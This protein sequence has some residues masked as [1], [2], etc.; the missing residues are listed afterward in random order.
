MSNAKNI[1]ETKKPHWRLYLAIQS[2]LVVAAV[3]LGG[4]ELARRGETYQNSI[5]P[6]L[7]L[8]VFAGC[9]AFLTVTVHIG[10]QFMLTGRQRIISTMAYLCVYVASYSVLS[11]AGKYHASRS[12]GHRWQNAGFAVVDQTIW[13]AKGVFWQPFV[14]IRGQHTYHATELGYFYSPLIQ[15]DRRYWHDS[16]NQFEDDLD[17]WLARHQEAS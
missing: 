17:E 9:P 2:T 3:V 7:G 4:I 11:S 14:T 13:H 12:G 1:L 6:Y 16:F 8:F 5:M 10:W 15:L